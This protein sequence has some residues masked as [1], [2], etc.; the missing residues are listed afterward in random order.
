MKKVTY[1]LAT[2]VLGL[3]VVAPTLAQE[4]GPPADL[5]IPGGVPTDI[6]ASDNTPSTLGPPAGIP[7]GPSEEQLKAMQKGEE[8]QKKGEE[9][10][11]QGEAKQLAGLK[12]GAAGM[13]RAL[14]QFEN[15]FAKLEKSG[16][17]LSENTREKL[18]SVRTEVE[19]IKSAQAASE[20]EDVDQDGLQEKL[21]SLGDEIG[22]YSQMQGLKKMLASMNRGLA[23]FEKQL[24]KFIRQGLVIPVVVTDDLAK[25]K[26]GLQAIND[27]K[28]PDDLKDVSPDELGDLMT[29]VNESRPQ[30]EMLSKWPRI[31]KQADQQITSFKK[32]L[33][34][35]KAL[36]DKLTTQGVDVTAD[37]ATFESD[38]T[39]LQTVRD[40]ADALIKAGQ[41]EEAFTKMEDEFFN[42][43]DNV[44]EHQRVIQNMANLSRFIPE[45]KKGLAAAKTQITK[46]KKKKIDTTELQSIYDQ[47]LA[48]GN[49]ITDMI[50]AKS[51]DDEAMVAAMDAMENLKQ[52]FQDKADEL[53]GGK[54]M[55]WD[56]KPP[57]TVPVLNIPKGFDAALEKVMAA[58]K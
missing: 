23:S 3:L 21:A 13:E 7:T 25:L 51:T 28:N 4:F 54:T 48:K 58:S 11:K 31:L 26:A 18:N 15:K 30:L 41:S 33:T 47:A 39:A 49:E 20:I 19:K 35:T 9:M 56:A 37:Y 46:L 10:Q 55:P 2:M 44:G 5:N 52:Q 17:R 29:K 12:K 22:G 38:V 6:P 45:F 27:A 8:M 53:A 34:K 42:N 57:G 43:L 40:E 1:L 14:K 36:V 16:L 32:Q 24:A 50:K